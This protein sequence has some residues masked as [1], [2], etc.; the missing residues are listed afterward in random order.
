MIISTAAMLF[1]KEHLPKIVIGAVVAVLL[2]AVA[3][4]FDKM[5]RET[6]REETALVEKGRS[7]VVTKT[8][9]RMIDD[10]R[11]SNDAVERPAPGARERVFAEGDRC[12]RPGADCF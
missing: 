11:K 7:E 10:I 5:E 12:A 9:E 4:W 8:Q 3:L 2:G 6:I 1:A